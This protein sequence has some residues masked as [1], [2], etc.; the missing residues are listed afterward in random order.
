VNY[1]FAAIHAQEAP[2]VDKQAISQNIHQ[3]GFNPLGV[4]TK[5]P[6]G[7][8]GEGSFQSTFLSYRFLNKSNFNPFVHFGFKNSSVS[9]SPDPNSG[10]VQ[11]NSNLNY[12]IQAGV[13]HR[14]Y[15]S[16]KIGLYAGLGFIYFLNSTIADSKFNTGSSIEHTIYTDKVERNGLFF[17]GTIEYGLTPK[18]KLATRV[19]YRKMIDI[20]TKDLSNSFFPD[21]KQV[22]QITRIY[23]KALWPFQLIIQYNLLKK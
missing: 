11:T 13:D 19:E 22:T 5:N 17:S 3:F 23:E 18:W 7:Y 8:F 2:K 6:G 20:S 4:L 16:S 9:S 15:I 1:K 21:I 12:Q 10:I 14:F